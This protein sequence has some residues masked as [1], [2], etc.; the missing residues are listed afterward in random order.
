MS[1]PR[2]PPTPPPTYTPPPPPTGGT[3]SPNRKIML[4]LSYLGLLCLI[5]LLA[6]KNDPEV[7]WHAKNGTVLAI[8]EI[9]LAVV[10]VIIGH[11]PGLNCVGCLI[12]PILMVIFL[13]I[14]IL[15]IIKALN[16]ER[17][18]IPVLSQYVDRF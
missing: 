3:V 11:V 2:V 9:L 16:G 13:V 5:P 12:W 7:Q 1:E 6:E 15:C 4:V 8:A 10:M 14:S 17:F 18:I